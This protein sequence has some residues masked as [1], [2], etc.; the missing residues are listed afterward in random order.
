MTDSAVDKRHFARPPL[1]LAAG[2][3][4]AGWGAVYS[5]GRWIFYFALSPVH[6]DARIWY[7]AAKA[8]LRYGWSTIYDPATLRSLSSSFPA[9]QNQIN[10][11]ATYINP[12]LLAWLFAPLTLVPEPVAYGLWTVVSLGSLVWAWY[13]A[14]PY[15]GLAKFTLLLLALAVWPVLWSF[16]LGQPTILILALVATAWRLCARDRPLAA[17][18]LLALATALKPQVT[19]LIPLA[20]LAGGRY[21]PVI[22]WAAAGALLG[23]VSIITLGS[24]GLISWWQALKYVQGDV[25]HA[26]FTLA[27]LF[28][29]GALTYVL[30][31]IQGAAALVIARRQRSQLEIVFAVGVL[32]SV[33]VGFHLHESDY[34]LLVIAGWLVLRTSPPLWH[35]LWLLIGV[36][37]M[38]AVTMG[39]PIPQVIWDAGWLGILAVASFSGSGASAPAIRRAA[40]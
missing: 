29:F 33:A 5:I 24:S 39:F 21:R 30:W 11:S 27:Y 6:G 26:Y 38:Q 8:G 22:G 37:T 4:A 18:A 7:V 23:I 13:I 12:P 17:G 32:G 35:R 36:A 40:G 25:A 9:G 14:A 1:W 16:Y 2:T 34:S 31:A 10:T 20:L 28:G 15:A 3:V 19:I